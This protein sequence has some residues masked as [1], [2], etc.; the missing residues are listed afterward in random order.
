MVNNK[1]NW[2]VMNPSDAK[3]KNI[4]H[5]LDKTTNWCI[6]GCWFTMAT[7]ANSHEVSFLFMFVWN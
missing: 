5:P 3:W 6:G 4:T 2:I 1:K 7:I